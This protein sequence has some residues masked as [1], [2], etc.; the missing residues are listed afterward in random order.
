LSRQF[1]STNSTM[2]PITK[3]CDYLVIG[4][5]SGGLASARRASGYYGAKTI[6]VE[7][8]RLGGTCVNVGYRSYLLHAILKLTFLQMCAQENHIQRCLHRRDY[9]RS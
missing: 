8:K 1:S 3:E 7:S 6:A 5:G 2:A 9:T 4:G